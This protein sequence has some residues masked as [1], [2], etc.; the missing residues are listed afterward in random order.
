MVKEEA[1]KEY[2]AAMGIPYTH[3]T[4]PSSEAIQRKIAFLKEQI[5]SRKA[6]LE[7]LQQELKKISRDK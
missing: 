5:T 3:D 7:A 1:T 6:E 2:C 4:V